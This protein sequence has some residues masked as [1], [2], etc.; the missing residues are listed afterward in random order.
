M[1]GHLEVPRYRSGMMI[2]YLGTYPEVRIASAQR[3]EGGNSS[4]EA[5]L[6][7]Y[8]HLRGRTLF[9]LSF[10]LD[11]RRGSVQHPQRY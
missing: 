6:I 5:T 11:A 4:D 7:R 1:S 9:P 3:C 10:P 2:E 8:V